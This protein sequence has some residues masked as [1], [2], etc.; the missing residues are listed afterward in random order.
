MLLLLI[1][2]L[3]GGGVDMV[4]SWTTVANTSDTTVKYG[5][6]SGSYSLVA[7]GTT[8]KCAK[9][10]WAL[11]KCRDAYVCSLGVLVLLPAAIPPT[12]SSMM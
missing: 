10:F 11:P 5:T 8:S 9:G 6:T 12:S 2:L 7:T 4:V 1:E 3:T